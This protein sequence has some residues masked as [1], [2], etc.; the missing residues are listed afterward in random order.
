LQ[1]SGIIGALARYDVCFEP[2]HVH[3]HSEFGHALWRERLFVFLARNSQR[4]SSYF[5]IPP[6]KVIEIGLVIEI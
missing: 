1:R 5:R 6:E 3:R 2:A 4:S